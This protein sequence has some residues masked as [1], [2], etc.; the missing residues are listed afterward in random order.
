MGGVGVGAGGVGVGAGGVTALLFTVTVTA[1]E[2]MVFPDESRATAVM[3]YVPFEIVVVFQVVAYDADVSSE[4]KLE[5]LILNCTP[6]TEILSV[7]LAEIATVPETVEPFVG[8]VIETLGGAVSGVGVGVG[9]GA[10]GGTGGV[11]GGVVA[12][13]SVNDFGL[14]VSN[15]DLLESFSSIP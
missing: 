11:G 12:K 8:D 5:P 14:P 13:L 9:E 3:E 10:G 7:A 1:V 2:V 4:P 15:V 6:T